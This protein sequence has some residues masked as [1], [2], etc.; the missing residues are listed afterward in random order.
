M[1]K[2]GYDRHWAEAV[3]NQWH[4]LLSWVP[5][6]FQSWYHFQ[7]EIYNYNINLHTPHS[8]QAYPLTWLFEVRPTSMYYV[9]LGN[10]SSTQILD[11]A[12]PLIWW[13]CTAAAFFLLGRAITDM[14]LWIVV[15]CSPIELAR[16]DRLG[17]KFGDDRSHFNN[18]ARALAAAS[19]LAALPLRVQSCR[20]ATNYRQPFGDRIDCHQRA[21]SEA[22][23]HSPGAFYSSP[24]VGLDQPALRRI[25]GQLKG[26]RFGLGQRP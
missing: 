22:G 14:A 20:I 7:A 2:T 11:I 4:G 12:N 16:R 9:D 21:Q 23:G 5:I 19:I 18:P 3:A 17:P 25:A 6:P 8:Y 10:G 13:A 26:L 15:M 24:S 1:T